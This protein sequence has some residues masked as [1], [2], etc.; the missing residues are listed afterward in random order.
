MRRL[1]LMLVGM[2]AL[3]GLW[4][5]GTRST[6]VVVSPPPPPAQASAPTVSE[7]ASSNPIADSPRAR[8]LTR[9]RPGIGPA[10]VEPGDGD[11]TAPASPSPRVAAA[12]A[13]DNADGRRGARLLALFPELNADEQAELVSTLAAD[14]ADADYAGLAAILTNPGTPEFTAAILLTDLLDRPVAT[15]LNTLLAVARQSEHPLADD[16]RAMLAAQMEQD[17]GTDWESWAKKI[18]E[19]LARHPE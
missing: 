14:T 16:A 19:W 7:E 8:L 2:A 1:W 6:S 17:H 13:D 3:A 15:R 4:L 12:L 9:P 18:S 11:T 10:A 5:W